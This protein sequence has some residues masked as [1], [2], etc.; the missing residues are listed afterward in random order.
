MHGFSAH[1][2]TVRASVEAFVD[3]LNLLGVTGKKEE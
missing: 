3:A 1:T 2:D